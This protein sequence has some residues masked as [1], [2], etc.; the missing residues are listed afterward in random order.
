MMEM[1]NKK[2][3]TMKYIATNKENTVTLAISEEEIRHNLK[4]TEEEKD[5]QIYL[6]QKGLTI[7]TPNEHYSA[8]IDEDQRADIGYT[9]F[10]KQIKNYGGY[11]AWGQII[12]QTKSRIDCLI[13]GN[14]EVMICQVWQDGEWDVYSS[15]DATIGDI[16]ERTKKTS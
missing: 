5:G 8:I 1:T 7:D 14:G 11:K 9:A 15:D 10:L 13:G 16:L 6:L 3:I 12:P 4:C 2:E